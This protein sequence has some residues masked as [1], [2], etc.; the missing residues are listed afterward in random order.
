MAKP[1]PK[2][3]LTTELHRW[4]SA[5][6]DFIRGTK[7]QLIAAGIC[8]ARWFPKKLELKWH[9]DGRPYMGN[10]GRQCVRR[11]YVVEDQEP[12]TMLMFKLDALG[13][14]LWTVQIAVDE[15]ERRRREQALEEGEEERIRRLEQRDVR[16]QER[17]EEGEQ[18]R[19]Q[20]DRDIAD[21]KRRL[22]PLDGELSEGEREHLRVLRALNDESWESLVRWCEHLLL[23]D[24]KE[25]TLDQELRPNSTTL[26]LIVDNTRRGGPGA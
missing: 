18:E 12:E 1:E 9:K 25:G 16:E 24:A 19:E 7:N 4:Q 13:V 20:Q 17:A 14:K 11:T 2:H 15:D 5:T 8:K 6:A 23:A 10:N 3:T 22:P 26:R 21:L